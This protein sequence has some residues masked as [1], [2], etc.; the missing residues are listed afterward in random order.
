LA[1]GDVL[2][3]IHEQLIVRGKM[4]IQRRHSLVLGDEPRL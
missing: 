3:L 1:A 4:R 2:R